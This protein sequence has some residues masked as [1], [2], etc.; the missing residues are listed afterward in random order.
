MMRRY[1]V[2]YSATAARIGQFVSVADHQRGETVVVST[3]RGVELGEI[4]IQAPT[5]PDLDPGP[6][7]ST[8]RVLRTAS[9]AD[10]ERSRRAQEECSRWFPV[11]SDLIRRSPWDIE[12]VDV[13]PLL[14]D[15]RVVLYYAGSREFDPAALAAALRKVVDVDVDPSF[16]AVDNDP[17]EAA[18]H[19]V[20]SNCDDCGFA[21]GHGCPDPC[22]DNPADCDG[23]VLLR[24]ASGR[25]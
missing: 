13:E 19:A 8:A 3:P 18:R 11:C 20:K 9:P 4:L 6:D 24:A 15:R 16:E 14:D 5:R 1:L 21:T 22:G 12:L 17:A 2:R 10:L 7:D 23:C 25:A